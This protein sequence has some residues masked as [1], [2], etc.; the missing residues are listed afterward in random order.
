MKSKDALVEGSVAPSL[1]RGAG[2]ALAMVLL[3]GFA[4]GR[5][6]W[7]Q[8][9]PAP[10][11]EVSLQV[12]AN[13]THDWV[14]GK[15]PAHADV[16][17]RALRNGS[18]I[19]QATVNTGTGEEFFTSLQDPQGQQVDLRQGDEVRVTTGT[20]SAVVRL[21]AMAAD[22]DAVANTVTGHVDG[23]PFP[24]SLHIENWEENDG[25]W[26]VQSDG[27]GHFSLS[28]GN[29]KVRAGDNMAIWYKQPDG[30]WSG[31]VRSHL[32]LETDITDEQVWGQTTPGARVDLTL[33]TAGGVQVV[34]GVATAWANEE[35]QF[36]TRFQ[37][38]DGRTL[39][40]GPGDKIEA[41]AESKT[42]SLVLRSPYR[43]SLDYQ[44]NTV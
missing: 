44:A 12:R 14:A 26:D 39:D 38:P 16:L 18:E 22:V 35:G 5:N 3:L 6:A 33:S 25:A 40:I 7:A 23:V 11:A 1:L 29:S 43:A 28:F 34:A 4:L 41:V 8:P 36:G 27:S 15:A 21:V 20:Q 30:N 42:S 9:G 13:R 24:A 17:V 32:G 2:V 37:T 10:D 19:G 31:I